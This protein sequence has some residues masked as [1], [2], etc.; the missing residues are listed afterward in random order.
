M[1]DFIPISK[2]HIS[3]R[4]EQYVIR[5]LRSGWVS[6]LGEFIETFEAQFAAYCGVTYALTTSNGTTGLHL[7][8]ESLGIGAGDE[9][10]VPDLTFIATANAVAYTGAKPVLADIDPH[11]LCLDVAAVAAAVTPHTRAVIPVHLYGHP[12]DMEPL[13]DLAATHGLVVL[14]DAAEAL[15]ARYK[16]RAVGSL[17]RCAVF[18]F[19]GNKLITTG[20]GGMLTTDDRDLYLRAKHLR[21]HA[22]SAQRRYWHSERGY[23]YRMTNL[24]AALGVA[25]LEQIAEFLDYR[26]RLMSWYREDVHTSSSVRLNHVAGWAKSSYWMICLEVDWFDDALRATFMRLLREVGVDTRPYFYPISSMPMYAAKPAPNALRKSS[27]GVNLPGYYGLSRDDVRRIAS[28]VNELL[29][30]LK[31]S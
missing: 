6:S 3:A 14:E 17:G 25:Q 18:S 30:T 27:I 24:Q 19:Y 21:D 2:P 22:M 7:A 11:T 28:A 20:E 31:P 29:L 12:A 8:L 23:N 15:G 26:G 4:E 10:I 16:N 5:A 9:V 13:N 1:S